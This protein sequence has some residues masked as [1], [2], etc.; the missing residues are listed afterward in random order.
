MISRINGKTLS[1]RKVKLLSYTQIFIIVSILGL[2]RSTFLMIPYKD[3]ARMRIKFPD[4]R[5][6]NHF[7]HFVGEEHAHF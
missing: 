7:L 5:L 1:P 4:I 2:L 3:F 6:F